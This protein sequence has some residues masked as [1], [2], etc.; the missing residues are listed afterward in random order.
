MKEKL[1][2][3][4]LLLFSVTSCTIINDDEISRILTCTNASKVR[5]GYKTVQNDNAA[6]FG[7]AEVEIQDPEIPFGKLTSASR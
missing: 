6:P 2:V 5:I 3:V 1:I 4:V 7:F